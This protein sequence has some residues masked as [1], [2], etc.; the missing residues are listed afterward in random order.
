M[1]QQHLIITP[2]ALPALRSGP[3]RITAAIAALIATLVTVSPQA[4]ATA[5]TPEPTPADASVNNV[6]PTDS[7]PIDTVVVSASR[8][9]QSRFDAPAAIDVVT[10]DTLHATSPL[11]NLSELLSTVPGV[12]VRNRE[13]YAQDLQVSV[14]GFGTRSTFGVRGVRILVDGIP[15]T[16]P[17]GQ[18]QAATASLTAAS[19]IEVLRGPLAQLYGNSAGGVV[20]VFTR[21]PA[22]GPLSGTVSVGAGSYDQ[23]QE[24]ASLSGGSATL[25]ATLDVSHFTTDGYRDHS[26][27]ERTEVA[28]KVVAHISPATTVTVVLNYFDQPKAQDPLGLTRAAFEQEPRQVI[29]AALTFN[30]R[31]TIEQKQVGLVLEHRLSDSDTLNA[32]VYGGTRELMQTLSLSGVAL[33]SAGGVVDLSRGYGGVGLNWNHQ[34]RVNGLPLN[35]TL[36]M[37]AD[38]L[39]ELR[40][41]Y[42]NDNGNAGALRRDE[43]DSARDLDFFGQLDWAFAPDWR[44][45]AGARASHVKLGVNDHYVTAASPNDSGGVSYRQTSPVAGLVWSVAD[46]VNLYANVGKGF[47]TPTLA[48]AAYKAV[49]TGPNLSLQASTSVQAELGAKFKR[50]ADT[51]DLALFNARSDAE[52]VPSLTI[53]GRSVYQNV[54]GVRRR[55]V[56]AAWQATRGAWSTHLSYTFLD[57]SF[58]DAFQNASNATIAAGNRL[59]GAPRHSLFGD[60][61]YQFSDAVSAALEMKTEA[62]VFVDDVNSDAAGGY[63]EFNARAG[64]RFKAGGADLFLYARVDNVLEQRY[65][66]S[67]IVN[68]GNGRFFEPAPGRRWFV[69]VRAA[70]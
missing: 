28:G 10:V 26:A 48:E 33:T 5:Q 13:N 58:R 69:G 23:R 16:M 6:A 19:R 53:N 42:V 14:R 44:V 32:R 66:G 1:N 55:G 21:D 20:Q 9:A 40:R 54:D 4:Q 36:G 64:Y 41:G 12:Q 22:V 43:S 39:H 27:A 18:G 63:A 7:A 70:L 8:A 24:G 59:P 37:E 61:Q 62:R 49:G 11:V 60:A 31:K 65:A 46:T 52:I 68:D 3:A 50:G 25:G 57:A 38:K 35:W 2:P 17:D 45:T 34:T 29:D 67:V 51:L 15:A 47:E 30:T 56:E